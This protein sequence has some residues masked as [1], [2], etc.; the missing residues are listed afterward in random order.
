MGKRGPK[1]LPE[2]VKRDRGT[3]RPDRAR[4]R[5]TDQAAN[6]P[7]APVGSTTEQTAPSEISE[8]RDYV[9]VADAYV[10]DVLAGRI[11]ACG[12][13]V[14]ACQRYIRMRNSPS[15]GGFSFSET[16]ANDVCRFVERL[17]HVEGRWGSETITLQPWQVWILVAC[18]GF[19]RL[20]GRRLVTKVYFQVARKSAKSTIVAACALYHLLREQEVGGQ[21]ICG[22]TTGAQARIVFSVMQRMVKRAAWLREAGLRVWANAITNEGDSGIGG[23]AKPINAKSSTQ[24]GLNPSFISLDES[25]AQDFELHD[26][27]VSALGA[28]SDAPLWM[29]TTA[30]YSLTSVGYAMRQTAIKIL[31]GIIESDHTFVA[32]YELDDA[33]DWR[34]EQVW[35]KSCPML[36]ITPRL[37]WV[38]RYRDDAIATPSMQGEFETKVCNRWLHGANRWLSM[39]AWSACGDRTL[40]LDAFS[41]ERAWIGVDLA[42]RDDIAAVSIVFKVNG[43][44][45]AFVRGYLPGL[46][47]TERSRAVPEYRA[48]VK[49][50]ELV[51]TDGNMTDYAVIEADIRDL[52]E[53]FD[54]QA[55]IV[56]RFGALHL[57]ATLA[58]DGLPAVIEG[59]SAK[60]FTTPAKE[61]EARIKAGKFRHAGSSFLTWQASNVCVERRRDGSLLPTKDSPES[62]NKIDGIDAILLALI[63]LL[64]EP[65]RAEPAYMMLIGA[66]A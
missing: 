15:S 11:V 50:G 28:R 51:T 47:V 22:A 60:T 35:Q 54:V 64:A 18:Y 56:E 33:D 62:P 27:L 55:I 29:P 31:D 24:D 4:R 52:C 66:T 36:G 46:V 20:D 53:R 61:L 3:Q 59:K 16:H 30:G 21:V 10:D 45:T 42:Q 9:S 19:R 26:V 40:T 1:P 44:I 48:W 58:A 5:R 2:K 63:P 39:P 65:E 43:I 13:L 17:P 32:L 37:D 38:K 57:A 25:H 6:L 23:H 7:V 8:A 14:K 12:W 34:D 41:G 49:S